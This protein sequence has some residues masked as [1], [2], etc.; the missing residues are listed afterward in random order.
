VR[1]I[2]KGLFPLQH[3]RYIPDQWAREL[4]TGQFA[5]NSADVTFLTSKSSPIQVLQ[6]VQSVGRR[7]IRR[8]RRFRRG[9][10]S[11][12]DFILGNVFL[13][14]IT[15][16]ATAQFTLAGANAPAGAAAGEQLGA[17]LGLNPT[18]GTTSANGFWQNGIPSG[19]NLAIT[20]RPSRS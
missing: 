14:G 17:N 9:S 2:S 7:F 1:S 20:S 4:G 18:P 6:S 8:R 15:T 13:K 10:Y 3:L 16:G 19:L 11:V 12:A 5:L